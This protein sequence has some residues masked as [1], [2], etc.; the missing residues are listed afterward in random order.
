MLAIEALHQLPYTFF[1]FDLAAA[2]DYWRTHAVFQ[3]NLDLPNHVH[4]W[5]RTSS[6]LLIHYLIGDAD[7][8]NEVHCDRL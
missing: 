2:W 7:D 5:R 4:F 3:V 8:L 6:L 1:Y